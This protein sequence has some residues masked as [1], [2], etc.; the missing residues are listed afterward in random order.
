MMKR[1]T[2]DSIEM[3]MEFKPLKHEILIPSAAHG[4]R[5]STG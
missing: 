3:L 4:K 5:T 2:A 1:L